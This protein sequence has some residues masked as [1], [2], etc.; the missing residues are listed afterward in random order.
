ME[1]IERHLVLRSLAMELRY[2]VPRQQ[3]DLF[4]P[5]VDI[6]ASLLDMTGRA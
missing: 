5:T 3:H 4:D 2:S 1:L 6:D